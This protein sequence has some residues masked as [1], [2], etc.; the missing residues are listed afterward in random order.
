M[1]NL[2]LLTLLFGI[3]HL[4]AS[5]APRFEFKDGESVALLGDSFI[6]RE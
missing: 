1:K 6:E 4:G 3:L 5:A 2:S